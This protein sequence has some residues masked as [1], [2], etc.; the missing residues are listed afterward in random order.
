LLTTQIE[1]AINHWEEQGRFHGNGD[2]IDHN[3]SWIM[4]GGYREVA[5][6]KPGGVKEVAPVM[7]QAVDNGAAVELIAHRIEEQ[8]HVGRQGFEG[9]LG[10]LKGMCTFKNRHAWLDLGVQGC[11]EVPNCTKTRSLGTTHFVRRIGR[12]SHNVNNGLEGVHSSDLAPLKTTPVWKC[13]KAT[14]S[15][16]IRKIVS[17]R[18]L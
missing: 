6:V 8:M 3:A 4:E 10:N 7:H 17:I 13:R 16:W 1:W 5:E 18:L 12:R 9:A 11:G 14:R 15:L 2:V